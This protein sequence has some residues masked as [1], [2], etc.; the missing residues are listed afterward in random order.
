MKTTL[1]KL[2]S[3]PLLAMLGASSGFVASS[4]SAAA[5]FADNF[6]RADN[7]N[8]NAV[9]TGKS[10]SLGALNWLE[11]DSGGGGRTLS[12]QLQLGEAGA[13]GGWALAY[14]DHN[15]TD[16]A[17]ATSGSFSVSVDILNSD[18]GGG[19]RYAGIA[20]GGSVTDYS[21]W[22]DNNPANQNIDFYIGYDGSGTEQF[23]IWENGTLTTITA[24]S[25]VEPD[26]LRVDFT[27]VTDFNA[28]TTINYAVFNN[29]ISIASGNFD[30]G[31]TDENYLGLFSNWTDGG[32]EMDNFSVV[33]EPSSAAL[34]L[35]LGSIALVL[36]RRK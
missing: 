31:G 3:L 35:G 27:N 19:T 24:L 22:T 21:G 18:T 2:F 29:G 34:L 15:F 5:L 9:A 23:R 33:P 12:N 25:F 14:L 17:I 13:G 10:G 20:V 32:V 11:K 28:G 1:N 16:T 7:D 26:T 8:L 36:R 30:W 4:A 6:D